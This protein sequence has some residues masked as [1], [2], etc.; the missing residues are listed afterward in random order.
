MSEGIFFLAMPAARAIRFKS[1]LDTATHFGLFVSL[2]AGVSTQAGIPIAF[3]STA[4]THI[5]RPHVPTQKPKP[6]KECRCLCLRKPSADKPAWP[7]VN[8]E[9]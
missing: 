1:G 7:V 9:D 4:A 8:Y 3:A 5:V 6:A 2:P